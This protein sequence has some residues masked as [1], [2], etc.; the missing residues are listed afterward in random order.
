[1]LGY[2]ALYGAETTIASTVLG[3][4]DPNNTGNY[5]AV[6]LDSDA[7]SGAVGINFGK[8]TTQS[9]YNATVSADELRGYAW[10][11]GAGWIVLNCADTTSGCSSTNGNFKVANDG[12]GLLSGYAWGENTGWINF[13]PFTNSDVSQVQITDGMFEG[14]AW[15]ENYG[16]IAFDCNDPD[17]CTE[18][19]WRAATDPEIEPEPENPGGG[20]VIGYM[21]PQPPQVPSTPA[22]PT[23]PSTTPSQQVLI[24]G[25]RVVPS[26]G[27]IPPHGSLPLG[28]GA[29]V[30]EVA[31]DTVSIWKSRFKAISYEAFSWWWLL[32]LII[33]YLAYRYIT[34]ERK[35]KK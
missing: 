3:T 16:W 14:Y 18:T 19:D 31:R 26:I 12:E 32:L 15:S 29:R 8:F 2:I 17:A 24:G 4:I 23:A 21:P 6:F 9:A 20:G 7:V 25:P 27:S 34:D 35:E 22:A 30:T 10:A 33:L 5:N 11:E 13:G 1:M 28:E